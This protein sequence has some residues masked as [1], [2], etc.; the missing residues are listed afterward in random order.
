MWKFISV[1]DPDHL[2]HFL[3]SCYISC[4]VPIFYLPLLQRLIA[5]LHCM[6]SGPPNLTWQ[7]VTLQ[8]QV[9]QL[10]MSQA[11]KQKRLIFM[12]LLSLLDASKAVNL[13]AL[14]T[15]NSTQILHYFLLGH[16]T[17]IFW[18]PIKSRWEFYLAVFLPLATGQLLPFPHAMAT[19]VLCHVQTIAVITISKSDDMMSSSNGNIFRVTGHLCGEF[20][21]L[22]WIPRTKASDAELWC[23]LLSVSK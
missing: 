15:I 9:A 1:T 16:L 7:W 11:W 4:N 2:T 22:R 5:L 19:Q 18:R 21:G 17:D 6:D 8:S 14:N 23:F 10:A 13:T 3:R 12:V 20:T